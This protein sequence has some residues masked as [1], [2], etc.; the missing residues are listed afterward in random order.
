MHSFREASGRTHDPNRRARR[1]F[2][3]ATHPA[4]PT[5]PRSIPKSTQVLVKIAYAGVNYIDIYERPG[6]LS[7]LY[8]LIP[9]RE[10]SRE[11]AEVGS[12]VQGVKIGD[13]VAFMGQSTYSDYAV[14]D[15]PGRLLGAHVIGTVSTEEKAALARAYGAEHIV[16]INNGYEALEKKVCELANGEGVHAVFDSVGQATFE[17]SSNIVRRLGTLMLFGSVS[18][19]I[20]LLNLVR[21]ASKNVKV[22][23][24]TVYNYI[25][26]REEFDELIGDALE[27][28]ERA[29]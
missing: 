2:H 21:L 5:I 19:V 27:H 18:G 26:T 13:R 22:T 17:S 4:T 11:V 12:E 24:T 10:G 28:S 25:M 3:P 6:K 23:W 29:S 8:L 20:P 14:I 7:H 16:L 1:R 15:T 9:G